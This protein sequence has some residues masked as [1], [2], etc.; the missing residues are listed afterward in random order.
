MDQKAFSS[1][2]CDS[3]PLCD[4]HSADLCCSGLLQIYLS[5]GNFRRRTVFRHSR[6]PDPCPGRKIISMENRRF[7]GYFN[8]VCFPVP[9]LL[10]LFMPFGSLLLP[11]SQD[12]YHEYPGGSRKMYWLQHLCN[13]M[14]AWCEARWRS[15]M[16]PMR[17]M[18]RKVSYLRSRAS[19]IVPLNPVHFYKST[20]I[21]HC[22]LI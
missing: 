1:Q 19:G 3:C 10:P 14:Q 20:L 15:G 5:C 4:C 12:R 17:R 18:Y 8:F 11:F 7:S 22:R 2:I 13:Y 16:C 21:F 9:Q 6:Q